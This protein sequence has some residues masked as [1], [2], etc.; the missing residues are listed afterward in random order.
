ME[1]WGMLFF[2]ATQSLIYFKEI[3]SL[4]DAYKIKVKEDG[5]VVKPPAV[6]A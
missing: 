1:F 5:S 2:S 6:Y 4:R 3:P